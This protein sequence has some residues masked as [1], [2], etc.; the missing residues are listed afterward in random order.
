MD[1]TIKRV[2]NALFTTLLVAIG[3]IAIGIQ[4]A[5]A[6]GE[7][8]DPQVSPAR[9]LVCDMPVTRADGAPLAIDEIA[10]I[11]FYQSADGILWEQIDSAETCYMALDLAAMD[12]GQYYYQVRSVDLNGRESEASNIVPFEL[13]RVQPPAAVTNLRLE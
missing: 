7:V 5:S 10:R 2:R 11:D 1:V 3:V 13:R 4:L 8:I 9:T 12:T 6:E